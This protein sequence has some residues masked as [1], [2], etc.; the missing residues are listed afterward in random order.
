MGKA[1]AEQCELAAV[2]SS[3]AEN[4]DKWQTL[5]V[6]H[7]RIDTFSGMAGMLLS[8]FSVRRFARIR[9]FARQFDPDIIYYPGGHAWKPVLDLV[10]P[11]RARVVATIHD[12]HLHPGEDSLAHRAFDALN[13]LRAHGYVLL[14]RSQRD[15]YIDRFA[16]EPGTVTVLPLGALDEVRSQPRAPSEV[17]S[18]S[19]LRSIAGSYLLFVGRIRSYKGISTLLEGYRD[20]VAQPGVPLVIAGSGAFSA[21]ERALLDSLSGADVHVINRWL[22]IEDI[23]ALIASAR[24]VVIPYSS[25]TQSGVI[26]LAS[27]LGVPTIASDAGGLSEQVLDGSTGFLFS[28][29]DADAL[30]ASLLEALGMDELAYQR[31]SRNARAYAEEH[32]SWRSLASQLLDFCTSLSTR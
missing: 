9:R 11:R 3:T 26:P 20:S 23:S 24:F 5:G 22:D 12:P 32:W 2:Y 6:P 31:M 30:G 28:A 17:P 4:A 29:G 19:G 13:R 1:L 16:L 15:A 27:A 25:A 21:E 14:N 7:L 8:M 18:F 10:L